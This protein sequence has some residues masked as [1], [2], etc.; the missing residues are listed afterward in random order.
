MMGSPDNVGL[1]PRIS[2]GLFV[3]VKQ[4]LNSMIG[5]DREDT[6]CMITVSALVYNRC[7]FGSV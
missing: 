6:K 7:R 3:A 1:I 4:K 5:T 2:G